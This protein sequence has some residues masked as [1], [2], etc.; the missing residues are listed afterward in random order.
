[1]LCAVE[2]ACGRHAGVV[3]ADVPGLM[4]KQP[5]TIFADSAAA[6]RFLSLMN[7]SEK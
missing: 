4:K 6:Q 7:E 3:C 5:L 1:M 2:P